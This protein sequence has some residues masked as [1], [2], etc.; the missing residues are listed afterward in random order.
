MSDRL[1]FAGSSDTNRAS[2]DNEF[3]EEERDLLPGEA[4]NRDIYRPLLRAP[5]TMA[6]ADDTT[7]GLLLHQHCLLGFLMDNRSF[8]IAR[9][10]NYIAHWG[11]HAQ[12]LSRNKYFFVIK[13]PTMEHMLAILHNGPYVI[14]G[15]SFVLSRWRPDVSAENIHIH[16]ILVW[17]RLYGLP[18]EYF[19]PVGATR[20]ASIVE[21]VEEVHTG[22]VDIQNEVFLRARVWITPNA[23]LLPGFYL[24]LLNGALI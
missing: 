4:L 13:F 9:I 3:S 11:S 22:L 15:A 21:D 2:S 6:L 19:N 8:S 23:L 24:C 17:I 5:S 7:N 18:T 10:Q 1:Y 20:L 12:V 14:D 16:K